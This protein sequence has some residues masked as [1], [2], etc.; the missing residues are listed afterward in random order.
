VLWRPHGRLA[1]ACA[2]VLGILAIGAVAVAFLTPAAGEPTRPRA[3]SRVAILTA[4]QAQL[5][6][7]G[8]LVRPGATSPVRAYLTAT[9]GA[10]AIPVTGERRAP[11]GGGSGSR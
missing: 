10:W 5:R 9:G 2:G 11:A 6:R 1:R 3:G 7:E 4:S 8:V